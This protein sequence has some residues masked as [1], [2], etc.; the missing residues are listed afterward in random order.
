MKKTNTILDQIVKDKT[1]EVAISQ[2][3]QS[4]EKLISQLSNRK[5]PVRSFYQ[6]LSNTNRLNLIAEIKKASPSEK[7][8]RTK[9]DP[10]KIAKEYQDSQLVAAISVLTEKKYFQ[11]DLKF[12]REVKKVTTVPILRKDFIFDK[13]QIY[14]SFLAE[15]DAVLLI[16]SLLDKKELTELLNLANSLK[17]DCLV[18]VHSVK[19]LKLALS[20]GVSIIGINAR[21][22]KNFKLNNDLFEKLAPLIPNKTIKVAESGLSNKADLDKVYNAGGNA[23]LIGTSILKSNNITEKLKELIL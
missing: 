6:S 4:L 22:L 2:K 1:K 7:I 14:E 15:A 20:V 5:T 13:Y 3:K 18:E 10:V 8:I 23:A 16:V 11:G 19:E 17:M 9:F 21:D 12:I